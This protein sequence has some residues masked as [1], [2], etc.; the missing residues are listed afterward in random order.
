MLN[1]T[2]LLV[3][4]F[5]IDY[6]DIFWDVAPCYD[7]VLDYECFV[8]RSISQYGPYVDVGAAQIG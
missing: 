5:S 4:S 8:Q 1:I 3:R 2:R 6:L 7:D